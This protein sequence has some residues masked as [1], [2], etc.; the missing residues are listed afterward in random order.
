MKDEQIAR[1]FLSLSCGDDICGVMDRK[2]CRCF[3]EIV[4]ALATASRAGFDAAKEQA[5]TWL[6]AQP[7]H[8]SLQEYAAAIRALEPKP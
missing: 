1:E 4:D 8:L 7:P 6:T 5:A 3:C 2:S